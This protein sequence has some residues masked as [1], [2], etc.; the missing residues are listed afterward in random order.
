MLNRKQRLSEADLI[1]PRYAQRNH[2]LTH[3]RR[4]VPGSHTVHKL[5]R[6]QNTQIISLILLPHVEDSR[7][8]TVTQC[9]A[10]CHARILLKL[11]YIDVMNPLRIF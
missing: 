4:H 2:T 5:P 6:L 11:L 1:H 7:R 10:V 9:P 3:L 8:E